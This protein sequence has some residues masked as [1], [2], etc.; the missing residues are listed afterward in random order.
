MPNS[1]HS[2]TFIYFVFSINLEII[3]IYSKVQHFKEPYD[4]I[5][6]AV[7]CKVFSD[8]KAT[9]VM[10]QNAHHFAEDANQVGNVNV[11]YLQ[12][13]D[14]QCPDVN[15]CIYIHGL[16]KVHQVKRTNEDSVKFY[17]ISQYTSTKESS[18]YGFLPRYFS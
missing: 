15:K 3:W 1:D 14:S 9:K 10:I 5:G 13:F 6:V 8:V 11:W 12:K 4:D 7:K 16:R 18:K 2:M 17:H